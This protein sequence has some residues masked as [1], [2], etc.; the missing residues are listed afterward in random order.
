MVT[1]IVDIPHDPGEVM[2]KE[3]DEIEMVWSVE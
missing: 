2:R 3:I 1:N